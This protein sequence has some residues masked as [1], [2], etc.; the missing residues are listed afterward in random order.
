MKKK[1]F[2]TQFFTFLKFFWNSSFCIRAHFLGILIFFKFY[3]HWEF[4]WKL[5]VNNSSFKTPKKKFEKIFWVF[6]FFE[7]FWIL[8]L[9]TI[10]FFSEWK[11]FFLVLPTS[12]IF[13]RL[14]HS[15]RSFLENKKKQKPEKSRRKKR[16]KRLRTEGSETKNDDCVCVFFSVLRI[17]WTKKTLFSKKIF[18]KKL[19]F[20]LFFSEIR[21]T[22]K[23][24]FSF[25]LR[26][27][28]IINKIWT[29]VSETAKKNSRIFS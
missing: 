24:I 26:N 14:T 8:K 19:M 15:R 28:F 9:K 22:W 25:K 6:L 23:K 18:F 10:I 7:I 4:W 29:L 12:L 3:L 20:H 5:L 17:F 2:S 13:L 1:F 16:K 21:K 11:K 27:N